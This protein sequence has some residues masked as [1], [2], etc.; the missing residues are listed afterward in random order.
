MRVGEKKPCIIYGWYFAFGMLHGKPVDQEGTFFPITGRSLCSNCISKA[1]QDRVVRCQMLPTPT[2]YINV[3]SAYQK[4]LSA[5]MYSI[6]TCLSK[7]LPTSLTCPSWSCQLYK[8]KTA[9]CKA[10]TVYKKQVV[11]FFMILTNKCAT[12]MVS[13]ASEVLH[14]CPC[15]HV[16]VTTVVASC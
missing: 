3:L 4:K 14:L 13:C 6:C 16:L 12:H 2:S 5:R 15:M 8:W 10:A 9:K 11:W 1:I 7:I